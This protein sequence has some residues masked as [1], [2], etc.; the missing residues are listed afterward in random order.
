MSRRFQPLPLRKCR[1]RLRF[2]VQL[3]TI[4]DL[5]TFLDDSM[6][7]PA[8]ALAITAKETSLFDSSSA[9]SKRCLAQTEC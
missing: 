1:A 3:S 8:A 5:G 9:R 2:A 4:R 7:V 6:A